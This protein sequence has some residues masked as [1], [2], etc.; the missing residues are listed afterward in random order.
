MSDLRALTTLIALS[1]L[2]FECGQGHRKRIH[3]NK[4]H[5]E[6]HRFSDPMIAAIPTGWPTDQLLHETAHLGLR[7]RERLRRFVWLSVNRSVVAAVFSVAH[8]R[9]LNPVDR[10]HRKKIFDA[11]WRALVK[12]SIRST[13]VRS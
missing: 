7:E 2:C 6:F 5:E 8:A 4:A 3:R 12:Q 11:A 10:Q 9:N 13:E 1:N